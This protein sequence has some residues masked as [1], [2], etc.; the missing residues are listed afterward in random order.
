MSEKTKILSLHSG[1]Q[2]PTTKVTAV[3]DSTLAVTLTVRQ[4]KELV[5]EMLLEE[6]VKNGEVQPKLLYN[7]EEAARLL[8]VPETWLG[9]AARQGI[10]PCVRMGRYVRFTANNLESYIEKLKSEPERDMGAKQGSKRSRET[11]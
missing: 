3:P 8:G 2:A 9:R 1:G 5:R 10:V 6:R 11:V 7:T 4:L